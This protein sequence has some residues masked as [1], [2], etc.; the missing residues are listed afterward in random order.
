MEN[1]GI[2]K[3][4]IGSKHNAWKGNLV[5]YSALHHWINDWK[6]KPQFCQ[7]C[8]NHKQRL[9]WANIDHK[10]RRVLEDY[11]ALCPKCHAEYDKDRKLRKY[12]KQNEPNKK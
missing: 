2:K 5:S 4:T 9:H 12:K 6:G 8:G 10:Y 1:R 7:N 11:I 3:G